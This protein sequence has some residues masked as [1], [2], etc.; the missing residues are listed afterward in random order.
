MHKC[1][2]N[3]YVV[4]LSIVQLVKTYTPN[5]KVR[6][7][8]SSTSLVIEQLKKVNNNICRIDLTLSNCIYSFCIKKSIF[9]TL[10]HMTILIILPLF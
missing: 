5:E 4:N 10:Q 8:N 7:L 6:G 1:Y 9:H 2:A 3:I